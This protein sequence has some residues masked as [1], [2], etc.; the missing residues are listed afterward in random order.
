MIECQ[1]TTQAPGQ[2][3]FGHRPDPIRDVAVGWKTLRPD[4][5]TLRPDVETLRPDVD[6]SG[7]GADGDRPSWT[8]GRGCQSRGRGRMGSGRRGRLDVDERPL[9]QTRPAIAGGWNGCP[10]GRVAGATPHGA[11]RCA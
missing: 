10:Q 6:E 3:G 11:S 8:A 4:V 7:G 1:D 2:D 5:E 9:Q